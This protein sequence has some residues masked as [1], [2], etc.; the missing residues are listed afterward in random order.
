MPIVAAGGGYGRGARI[1]SVGIASTGLFTA[2]YFAVA[3]HVLSA[4]AVKRVDLLWAVTFVVIS[5][6]YRPDERLLSRTLAH[7]GALGLQ[8]HPLRTPALIQASFAALFVVCALLLHEQL[9]DRLFDGSEALYAVLLAAV[10]FYS[11][12]YFARGWLAGHQLFAHYGGLTLLESLSRFA[13][14]LAVAVGLTTGEVAVAAGIAA[15]PCVSLL[16]VPLAFRRVHSHPAAEDDAA[17]DD[18][19]SFEPAGFALSVACIMLAEQ[20]LLNAPVLTVDATSS[21]AALAGIVFNVL[22]IARAPLQL[23][24]AIQT[25]LLPH[26]TGL[27]ATAGHEAFG[28]AVRVTLV[29]I[30][31]FGLT[32]ALALL[33]AGPFVMSHVFGQDYNYGRVGLALVGIGMGMHLAAGALNQSALARGQAALAG[34][35]WIA[36]AA[37]FVVWILVPLVADQLLRVELG[38]ALATG[39]LCGLLLVVYRSGGRARQ[40]VA[41]A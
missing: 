28:R 19:G 23:F 25:S 21:N 5:V 37:L 20:A 24:Q 16:V 9:R 26:L 13:F 34:A 32:T 2:L 11:V 29:A 38:Y 4:V 18:T 31:G 15:A 35:T 12:S 22:L 39:M 8:S 30:A 14:V 33:V 36:C 6:I 10:L 1:L 3:S 41:A 7:R 27:E 40:A 17:D